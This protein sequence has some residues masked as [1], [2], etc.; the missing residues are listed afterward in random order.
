MQ[1]GV[2]GVHHL[3]NSASQTVASGLSRVIG[4]RLRAL[5]LDAGPA[6]PWAVG[7]VGLVQATG[8]WLMKRNRPMRREALTDYLT[9]LLWQGFAGVKAAADIPGG[10]AGHAAVDPWG[11]VLVRGTRP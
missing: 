6:E 1:Q 8:D 9:T 7:I 2:P 3:V 10:L 5:G 4:A 11:G